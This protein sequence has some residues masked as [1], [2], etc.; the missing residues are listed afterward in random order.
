MVIKNKIKNKY[1]YIY[2]FRKCLNNKT[3][4]KGIVCC[5]CSNLS[6]VILNRRCNKK[7]VC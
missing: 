7:N 1:I 5:K 4:N 2:I 3:L 6:Y